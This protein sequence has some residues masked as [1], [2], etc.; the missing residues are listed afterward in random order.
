MIPIWIGTDLL[1]VGSSAGEMRFKP[2][3]SA[4]GRAKSRQLLLDWSERFAEV[5]VD[6]RT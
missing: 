4:R 3:N 2:P 1:T 5:R 6:Y